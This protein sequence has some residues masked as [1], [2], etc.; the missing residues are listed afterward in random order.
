MNSIRRSSSLPITAVVAVLF[1]LLPALPANAA[2]IFVD[3][4]C[5]LS[6]AIRSANDNASVGGCTAGGSAQPDFIVLLQD[7][8]LTEASVPPHKGLPAITSDI[9]LLGLD[10]SITR[11]SADSFRIFTLSGGPAGS[12]QIE[13]TTISGGFTTEPGGGFYVENGTSLTIDRCTVSGNYSADSGGG[14]FNEGGTVIIRNSLVTQ[15]TAAHSGAGLETEFSAD[16]SNSTFSGNTLTDADEDT[17]IAINATEVAASVSVV[18]STFSGNSS[19]SASSSTLTSEVGTFTPMDVKSSII[20]NTG[21]GGAACGEIASGTPA[22]LLNK[23]DDGTCSGGGDLSC[24]DLALADNGGPTQTHALLECSNA[25]DHAGD[26]GQAQDQRGFPRDPSLC[27][28]GAY[29]FSNA[30][31]QDGFESGD[32]SAWSDTVP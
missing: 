28:S 9:I 12:L 18:L 14:I 8:E 11:N 7:V 16:I 6:D 21:G 32:T 10:F 30:L 29:E 24:F 1:G 23:D 13:Y 19:D 17:G 3:N 5:S 20:A 15:N 22:Q 31:F 25:I 4:T 2:V 27:D 26:C